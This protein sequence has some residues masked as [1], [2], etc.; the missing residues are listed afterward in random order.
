VKAVLTSTGEDQVPL[1]GCLCFV[2]PEGFLA[3]VGLPAL[4]TLKVNG[5]PL[6]YAK[7]LGK[8]LNQPGSISHERAQEVCEEVAKAL[9]SARG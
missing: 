6:Y 2:A 3:D 8:R 1:H 5:F 7:R 9:P 4:R